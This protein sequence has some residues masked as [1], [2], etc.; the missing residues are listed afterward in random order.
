M[1]WIFLTTCMYNL[2]QTNTWCTIKV[3]SGENP[4]S[5]EVSP[6]GKQDPV[7]LTR[8]HSLCLCPSYRSF[9]SRSFTVILCRL[10]LLS[11]D[12]HLCEG[13]DHA[14]LYLLTGPVPASISREWQ[15][16]CPNTEPLKWDLGV[17]VP[18]KYTWL[19]RSF[20]RSFIHEGEA[21]SLL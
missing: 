14:W 21:R 19:I 3:L 5:S 12:C 10:R 11:S 16:L 17:M 1:V 7:L 2:S 6:S 20:I 15:V 8:Q 9:L 13:R 4:S 18:P